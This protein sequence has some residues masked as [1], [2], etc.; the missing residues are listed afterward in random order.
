MTKSVLMV[1]LGEVLWDLLPSGKMLGGA[2]ANFAYAANLL[3]D[4]GV[5]ASR[6]GNDE[7]GREAQDIFSQRGVTTA[8]VQE[9]DLHETG[10]AAVAVDAGGQPTFTINESV[11]WDFLE[12]TDQWKELA[13]RADV[14]CFGSLAQRCFR[15]ASTIETFLLHTR[16]SALRIFDANLRQSFYNEGILRRSFRWANIVKLN[17]QELMQVSSLFGLGPASEETLARKLLQICDLRLICVTRGA[18]GSLLASKDETAVHGGFNVE[19]VDAVG[20]GDIF[21]ACVAH[22]YLDG[23]SLAKIGES[24]NRLASWVTTQVGATPFATRKQVREILRGAALE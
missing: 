14:V 11:A 24:A 15:S 21:T 17:E 19:V 18:H 6:V 1:G 4:D 20:A 7:L 5:I 12:W 9:D 23:Q 10:T 13:G 3:G 8:Y 22:N 16:H 2:P